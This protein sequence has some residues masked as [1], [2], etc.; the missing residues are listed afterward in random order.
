MVNIPSTLNDTFSFP[1]L[2]TLPN[3]ETDI[4]LAEMSEVVSK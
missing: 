1:R 3:T 2:T 4:I